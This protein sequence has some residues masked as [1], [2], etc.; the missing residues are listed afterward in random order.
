MERE[1]F[2][3]LL[4]LPINPPESD[5]KTIEAAISKK[6]AEWSRLRNHPSKGVQAQKYINMI[7]EIR[8]VMTDDTLRQQE[9]EAAKALSQRDKENKYPEIDGHIELLLGKGYITKDE[10]IKLAEVHGVKEGEIQ[11]RIKVK[12]EE[13]Y[14]RVDRQIGLRRAKGYLTESEVEKIAKRNGLKPDDVKN[15]V[16]CPIHKNDKAKK[17]EAPRQLERSIEKTIKDNLKVVGKS[18]LYDF[19]G[20]PESA[21]LETIQKAAADKKKQLANVAKKDA[22]A[23]A[24]NT[25]AGQCATIFKNEESRN[26]YDVSLAKSKLTQLDSDIDI[27]GINGKIRPEYFDILVKK[28]MDF[29]MERNEAERYIKD[30]CK[31]KNWRVEMPSDKKRRMIIGGAVTAVMF[32]L[33]AAGGFF[34]YQHYQK[35]MRQAHYDSAMEEAASKEKPAE[36]INRLQ[37]F[38]SKYRGETGYA[39]YIDSA[40]KRIKKFEAQRAAQTFESLQARLQSMVDKGD[41]APAKQQWQD[42]LSTNPPKPYAAKARKQITALDKQIEKR[43][44]QALKQTMIDGEA[45]EKITAIA[46]FLEKHPEG[47]HQ[48][49]ARQMRNDLSAEYYVFV[50]NALKECEKNKNWQRCADLCQGYM[51]LYDNSHSDQL[52]K[53]IQV[54]NEKIRQN[55]VFNA[56]EKKADKKGSDYRAAIK[57]Y[58][59]YLSAYPDAAI[60]D[61]IESEIQKLNRKAHLK[62]IEETRRKLRRKL[63]AAGERFTLKADGVVEDT[64]TGL[65]WTIIDSDAT[66]ADNQCLTYDR[67]KAYVDDLNTGGYTDWRLPTPE[68]IAGIYKQSPFFPTLEEKWYWTAKNYSSYSDGWHRIVETVTNAHSTDWSVTRVDSRECGAVRA[69]RGAD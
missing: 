36:K 47:A 23:T 48:K 62:A 12:K 38:I 14:A 54:Y 68:E 57:V 35:Q 21:E 66:K 5:L 46:E 55:R 17:D 60:A 19:L 27:S 30:Y 67:A 40:R 2:Y 37:A 4:D 61:R 56:L 3:I 24:G 13:K 6:Q 44:F 29:G 16:H 25:L 28:A 52:E 33:V 41:I 53:R 10:T 39:A 1:N 50:Q 43:D 26:A 15:R 22:T 64:K 20:V 65:M 45:D 7:P 59:D 51:D 69:V 9:A 32:I 49:Q 42:Y 63:K 8:R 11:E 58:E 34:Y 31:R 18:S